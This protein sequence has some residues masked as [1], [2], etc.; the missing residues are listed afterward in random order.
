M[1]EAL[2]SRITEYRKRLENPYAYIEYLECPEGD[3]AMLVSAVTDQRISAS[4][5]LLENPYAYSDGDGGFVAEDAVSSRADRDSVLH[6]LGERER[7]PRRGR[8][9]G[10]RYTDTEIEAIARGLQSRLWRERKHLWAGIPPAD[11]VDLLDIKKAL[12]LAGYDLKYESGLGRYRHNGDQIEV[13][14]LID[15]DAKLVKVSQQFLGPALTFTLAHELGHAVL[16]S[17]GG[18]VHRDRPLDGVIRPREPDELEADKFATYFLMPSKL[19]TQRFCQIFGT[20]CFVLTDDTAFALLGTTSDAVMQ[21]Y[22]K[23][24]DIAH[25]LASTERYN[26]RFFKS[27]ADQFKVSVGAMAIRLEELGRLLQR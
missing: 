1:D 2:K 10:R 18:G 25:L 5:K 21:K 22:P 23:R 8:K 15:R 17:E 14:G 26:N 9:A 4:R 24:R 27:L 20:E 16:H 12:F 6:E 19:V 3:S 7:K 13:A 11:P